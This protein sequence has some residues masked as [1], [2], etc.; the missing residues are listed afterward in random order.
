MVIVDH[1]WLQE[2][3]DRFSS[4]NF[5]GLLREVILTHPKAIAGLCLKLAELNI[6]YAVVNMGGGVKK[7]TNDVKVCTKCGGTGKCK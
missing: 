7:V 2:Q 3:V 6:S 5:Q 1:T 4:V